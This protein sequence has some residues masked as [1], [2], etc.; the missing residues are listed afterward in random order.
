MLLPDKHLRICESVLGLAALVLAHLQ[1]PLRFDKLMASLD[2]V[3]GSED[4][5]ASHNAETTTLALCVLYA[6][7]LVDVSEDGDIHRCA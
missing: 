5:P 1:R 6:I 7:G 4:W 3:F 2:A